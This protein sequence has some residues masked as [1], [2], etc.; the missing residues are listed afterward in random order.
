MLKDGSGREKPVM[1]RSACSKDLGKGCHATRG[2]N[3]KPGSQFSEALVR[4][5]DLELPAKPR[6]DRRDDTSSG[7]NT[8]AQLSCHVRQVEIE[9]WTVE[10]PPVSFGAKEAFAA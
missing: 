8:N 5:G 6:G 7:E 1:N 3:D 2:I 9:L 4:A 10:M